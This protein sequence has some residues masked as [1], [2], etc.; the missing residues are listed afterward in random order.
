[1]HIDAFTIHIIYSHYLYKYQSTK[2]IL[3]I[4]SMYYQATCGECRLMYVFHN[5]VYFCTRVLYVSKYDVIV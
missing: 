3:S 1:M 4:V 2:P 5:I